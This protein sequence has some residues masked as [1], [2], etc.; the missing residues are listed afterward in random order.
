MWLT[1]MLPLDGTTLK[2]FLH[3]AVR[4]I[5]LKCQNFPFLRPESPQRLCSSLEGKSQ[6][7]QWVCSPAQFCSLQSNVPPGF[8]ISWWAPHKDQYLDWHPFTL[9]TLPQAISGM[10]PCFFQVSTGISLIKSEHSRGQS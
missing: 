9:H 6:S 7:V 5:L 1:F 4:A 2:S 3:T 10:L 8:Q